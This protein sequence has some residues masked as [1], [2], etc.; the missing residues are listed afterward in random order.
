MA[1]YW[2]G[3]VSQAHV[4]R[5]V[6]GGFA[7][8]GHGK[9]APLRRLAAGDWL[10]YYSP[11][12]KHPDGE[13]LQAFT[14]IGE[15]EDDDVFQVESDGSF[16]PWRR[17]VRYLPCRE[18][19]AAELL[20]ELEIVPDPKRWGMVVRRGLVEIGRPDFELIARAMLDADPPRPSA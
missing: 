19:R 11:R 9:E 17:R 6:A 16:R 13:P 12:R 14:A 4:L 5:G 15:V 7:Q 2:I 8:L 18:A 10:V 20:P 1:R 3:V